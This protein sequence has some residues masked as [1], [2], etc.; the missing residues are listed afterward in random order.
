MV[1]LRISILSLKCPIKVSDSHFVIFLVESN[2]SPVEVVN[3]VV[4][5]Q[6]YRRIICNHCLYHELVFL[7]YLSGLVV[8]TETHIIIV[9]G[10]VFEG[11]F[12][13]VDEALFG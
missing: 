5:V 8:V 10:E 4:G 7:L 13:L 11:A 3:S 2:I 6:L 9:E 1:E 12:F